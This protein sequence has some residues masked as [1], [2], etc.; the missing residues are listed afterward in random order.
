MVVGTVEP[1]GGCAVIAALLGPDQHHPQRA[2]LLAPAGHGGVDEVSRGALE[3]AAQA[4][5]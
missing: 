3:G 5:D 2:P 4:E 1:E